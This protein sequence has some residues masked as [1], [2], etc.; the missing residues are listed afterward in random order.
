MNDS[1]LVYD[2]HDLQELLEDWFKHRLAVAWT[3][4]LDILEKVTALAFFF[5]QNEAVG[6]LV[7]WYQRG[8][9]VTLQFLKALY[10]IVDHLNSI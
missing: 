1:L 9:K 5:N 10:L 8:N 4:G 3:V 6:C 7:D 2:A